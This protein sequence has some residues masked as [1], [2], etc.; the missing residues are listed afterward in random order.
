[1]KFDLH[2]NKLIKILFPF[3]LR[4]SSVIALVIALAASFR[5]IYSLFMIY[6]TDINKSL[7]YNAQY[8]LLQK[9]LNDK[10]DPT[11]RR[12]LVEDDPT[13]ITG[14][15]IYPQTYEDVILL[16]SEIENNCSLL[17]QSSTWGFNPFVVKLPAA[18]YADVDIVNQTKRHLDI[19]K[20][21]GTKYT[22]ISL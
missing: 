14:L 12:I 20:Y 19:Y 8:P 16:E 4:S 21:F 15:F 2:I 1:M 17:T 13:T 7:S 3:T 18:L 11:D 22:I 9:L 6:V 10:L 5:Y